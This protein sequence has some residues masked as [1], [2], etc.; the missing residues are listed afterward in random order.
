MRL[1]VFL[2]VFLLVGCSQ[3]VITTSDRGRII[4]APSIKSKQ[5]IEPE[6]EQEESLEP[7]TQM[8]QVKEHD[9]NS[10][11]IALLLPLSGKYKKLGQGMLDA[12][13]L[14]LF[15]L[16]DPN[17]AI[18]P[19]DTK[20]TSYGA[21][22]AA[23]KAIADGT[24]IILGPIF[25]RSARGIAKLAAENDISVVSFSNDRTLADSG[26][27]ALGF[28]PEQQIQKVIRLSLM[29][30]IEDYAAILPNNA[31]GATA[32]KTLRE[33]VKEYPGA[34][35]LKTEI[36]RNDS[37]RNPMKLVRHARSA[38]H[39]VLN[40]KPPKDFDEEEEVYN[41][42][43]IKFPRA[44]LVPEG[45]KRL[46]EI[47]AILSKKEVTPDKITL[48]GSGQWKD[49]DP[50]DPLLEGA[51]F[52]MPPMEKH[53]E[54]EAKFIETYGYEAPSIASLA[55]DALALTATIARMT[56]GQ[57]FGKQAL[58]NSRGFLGIDGIFRLQ[59]NGLTERGFAIMRIEDGEIETYHNAPRSFRQDTAWSSHLEEKWEEWNKL[60]EEKAKLKAIA[61]EKKALLEGEETSLIEK[62]PA[63]IGAGAGL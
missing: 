44:I 5:K 28:R 54:F 49:I 42:N 8:I 53:R 41:E 33:T 30:G 51:F 36:Y 11:R 40:K 46:K 1:L 60:E 4:S 14:V 48:I 10:V 62:K 32:A 7:E 21:S 37:K 26:V 56:R 63:N 16:D 43:P 45:G 55:Y 61:D 2:L 39:A 29:E 38:A 27:F 31:F 34:A 20:G 12:A 22:Q 25:S 35:V 18:M 24:R 19:Y 57:D 23:K 47:L 15:Y 6:I 52:A 50:T 3:G 59:E 17:L 58:T 13:Q 9:D